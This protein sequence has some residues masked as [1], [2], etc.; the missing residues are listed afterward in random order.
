MSSV[1]CV[2][3]ARFSLAVAADGRRELLTEPVALAPEAGRTPVIGEVSPAA[4]AAGVR[5]GLPL[6][7]ALARCPRL[8]LLPPDPVAV[9]A[10]WDALV[11]RLEGIG[12]AVETA[13]P[14]GPGGRAVEG[15]PGTAWFLAA[16][17]RRLHGGSL[18]GI[19]RAVRQAL[20]MPVRIGA[21]PSRFLARVAAGRA[22]VRRP[23]VLPPG[24]G[25]GLLAGE[26]V[27]VLALRADLAP[28]VGPLERL[29]VATLGELAALPPG[30]VGERFGRLGRLAQELLRGE[31]APL[32]PRDAGGR[33][34]ADLLLPEAA[35]GPQLTHALGLLIDRVLAD[36]ARAHRPLR[37]LL[38]QARLVERGTWQDRVVL[39]E[40]MSD[41]DRIRLALGARLDLLPSP[42]ERLALRVDGFGAPV[43]ADRPLLEE[44]AAI[45]HARLR[46]AVRQVRE[47]AGPDGA[48][49]VVAVDPD[50][51]V[52]E[53]RMALT[54]FE[55]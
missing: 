29:G 21:A 8:R 28:L 34:E 40:A 13:P 46:E 45:R 15:D 19:V 24:E 30:T 39:R 38:L 26:P 31:E 1:V 20:G 25:L 11:A 35:S 47:V 16:G 44:D 33:I 22:R 52:A 17:L 53:R 18:D 51:R 12:A 14:L 37:S 55:P 43:P 49:R 7:E 4:E 36:P 23:V 6:G 42:A 48:L 2:H 50:S 41:P 32:R 5:R 27:S 3:L 10:R 54:P 9:Q